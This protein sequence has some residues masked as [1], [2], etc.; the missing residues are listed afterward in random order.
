MVRSGV[1]AGTVAILAN[2]AGVILGGTTRGL[3]AVPVLL[4]GGVAAA[5]AFKTAEILQRD[6]D[7]ERHA[8]Q[9][10]MAL[11]ALAISEGVIILVVTFVWGISRAG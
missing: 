10:G 8:S 2:V 1:L 9:T 6:T 11:V 5:R 7:E 3:V 4:I